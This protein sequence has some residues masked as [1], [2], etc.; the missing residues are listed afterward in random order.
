[1]AERK[2]IARYEKVRD[3]KGNKSRMRDNVQTISVTKNES[4]RSKII[5]IQ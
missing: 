1:M 2:I 4:R 5:S 3:C